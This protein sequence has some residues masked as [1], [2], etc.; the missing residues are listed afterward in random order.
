M[1][2]TLKTPEE[3]LQTLVKGRPPHSHDQ[4]GIWDGFDP[5]L[6]YWKGQVAQ[7]Q[8]GPNGEC[9]VCHAIMAA[10][11]FLYPAKAESSLP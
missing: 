4:P 9:Y 8:C 5:T 11:N 7:G 2:D 6:I 3:I 1:L 10:R